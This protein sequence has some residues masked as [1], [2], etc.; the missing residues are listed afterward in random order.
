MYYTDGDPDMKADFYI[1]RHT[2]APAVLTENFFMAARFLDPD[3]QSEV[4]ALIEELGLEF[5]GAENVEEE[6]A[7]P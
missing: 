5:M 6:N 1:L 2:T 7:P 3:C 4:E